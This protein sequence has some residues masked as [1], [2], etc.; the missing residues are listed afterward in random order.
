MIGVTT[1]RLARNVAFVSN[2]LKS[3]VEFEAVDFPQA[4]RLTVHILAAVAEHEAAAISART[5]AA[6]AAAKARGVKL[7]GD[8]GTLTAEVSR[9]R[10]AA[11]VAARVDKANRRAADLAPLLLALKTCGASLSAIA[12]E[13]NERRIPAPRGGPWRAV[14]VKR[15]L[16]RAAG[17]AAVCPPS[18]SG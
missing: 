14:Q 9:R 3:G 8:R 13:L 2:L 7:G 15:A 12:S 5:K 1:A 17:D 10:S 18:A 6:L 16:A 11:G 4:N